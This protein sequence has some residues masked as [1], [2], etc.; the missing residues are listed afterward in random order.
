MELTSACGSNSASGGSEF[1]NP[2]RAVIG[3]V[4]PTASNDCPIDEVIATDTSAQNINGTVSADCSISILLE[5]DN[6]YVISF[7]KNSVFVATLIVNDGISNTDQVYVGVGASPINLGT[8]TFSGDVCHPENEPAEQND[9]DSDG[10]SDFK[11]S[12]DN[13]DGVDDGDEP[14]KKS[15]SGSSSSSGTSEEL[16]D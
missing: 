4:T 15:S 2:Q 11:D 3:M 14:S 9:R 7:L 12:D 8:V 1:G 10:I 6:E 5:V 13:N 16:E